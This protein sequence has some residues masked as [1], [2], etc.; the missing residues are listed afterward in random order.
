MNRWILTVPDCAGVGYSC[1]AGK[2]R[3]RIRGLEATGHKVVGV[4][5][6]FNEFIGA[7]HDR[8]HRCAGCCGGRGTWRCDSCASEVLVGALVASVAM[9]KAPTGPRKGAL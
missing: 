7:V 8:Q 2:V 5:G 9:C 6:T 3:D 4:Y 1:P